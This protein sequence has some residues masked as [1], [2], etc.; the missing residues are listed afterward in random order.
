MFKKL[1]ASLAAVAVIAMGCAGVQKVKNYNINGCPPT[2]LY[3]VDENDGVTVDSKGIKDYK[4]LQ[5]SSMGVNEDNLMGLVWA[6]IDE[7]RNYV[8][9]GMDYDNDCAPDS[10][11]V[12]TV[13]NIE[14]FASLEDP[15]D[16]KVSYSQNIGCDE[17][18][19]W[20]EERIVE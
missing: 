12:Y 20:F 18:Q 3:I 4:M 15:A 16:V 8:V 1:M 7:A 10:C 13:D 14:E 2:V 11:M 5:P 17:A 19:E 6:A 9:L